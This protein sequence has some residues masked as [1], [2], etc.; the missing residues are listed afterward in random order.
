MKEIKTAAKN[1]KK[2]LLEKMRK[3]AERQAQEDRKAKD[4]ARVIKVGGKNVMSRS[5]KPV[6]KK[7]V[8]NE[9][10]LT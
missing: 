7:E 9:N 1:K 3:Q 4:A 6:V 5:E 2:E 10:N 8:K